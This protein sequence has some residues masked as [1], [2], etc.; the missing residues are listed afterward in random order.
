VRSFN[1]EGK[2][3][4]L[5]N[6]E[7]RT[8]NIELF[9]MK[10]WLPP[11]L[12][13]GFIFYMSSRQGSELPPFP[14]SDKIIHF[15]VYAI[16]G[17]LFARALANVSSLGRFEITVIAMLLSFFYGIADEVHQSFVPSR[18][19]ELYDL[20]MDLAGGLF[21]ATLYG[22]KFFNCKKS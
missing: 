4:R 14:L 2:D 19:A 18:T 9:N 12:W 11:V 21:G 5:D 17:F 8:S 22:Y 15:C 10:K 7:L 1:P 3:G 6:L 13:C 20:I 16:L